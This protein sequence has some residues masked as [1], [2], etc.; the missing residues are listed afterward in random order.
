MS[1]LGT[2]EQQVLEA[3]KEAVPTLRRNG[4]ETEKQRWLLEENIELLEKAGVFRAAVPERFGGLDL[5]LAE[6]AEILQTIARGCGST[7]WVS[8]VWLSS[9]WIVSLYP[10][11]AQEEVFAGG[12][13]R[14]SGGFT[15]SGTLTPVEGGYRLSGSWRFNTGVPGA[16]WNIHAAVAEHPDGTHEELFALVPA[17]DITI[18]DDWDVFGAAGTGSA[19]STVKD[20]FV[21]AH[22]V[23]DA[24]VYEAATGDRWNAEAKG[25]NYNLLSYIVATCAPVYLGIADSALELFAERVAGKPITYTNWTDQR[26][27]PY[28]QVT[29][30]RAA[31]QIAAC[32]AL[33]R[34]WLRVI[35]ERA[36]RGERLTVEEKATIRGQVGY[37]VEATKDAVQML[38][39]ISSASTI[40]R[41]N[42]FQRAFRD[43]SALSLHGLLAPTGS[44]EAHGRVLLGLEPGTDYL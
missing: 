15:P 9:T 24:S 31:N 2:E 3:V 4:M 30:G 20:V 35:Q 23:V 33:S 28:T 39:D 10:D 40:V 5:P 26:E 43:I 7:G 21:P 11:R 19:T 36:D 13:V 41:S 16:Q 6:Q 22:R 27:H 8:M 32:E 37:V 18:A 44:L 17:E 12:S 38:F 34:D 42:H 29:V 1:P 25:R 14:V